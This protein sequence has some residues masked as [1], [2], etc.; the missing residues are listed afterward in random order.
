MPWPRLR[1]VAF[2]M[3]LGGVLIRTAEVLADYGREAVL[4][5]VP[6]SGVLV[7]MALACLGANVLGAIC[8]RR[9]V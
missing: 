9:A 2:W 1:G 7:W 4:P 5:L 3:L 6:L 8:H